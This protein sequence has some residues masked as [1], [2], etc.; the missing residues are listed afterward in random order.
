MIVPT[1]IFTAK[2]TGYVPRFVKCEHCGGEYVYVI[3]DEAT[4]TGRSPLFVGEGGAAARA[5]G[6]AVLQLERKL[7]GT[8]LPM[9]CP[10]C[11]W[12]QA[13]MVLVKRHRRLWGCL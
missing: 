10:D 6:E 12:L 13:D 7:Q 11:G 1:K 2:V 5:R 9:P 8:V 3:R 4:G